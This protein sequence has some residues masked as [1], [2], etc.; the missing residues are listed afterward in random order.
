MLTRL[1][2][3]RT[4]RATLAIQLPALH[5]NQ[6]MIPFFADNLNT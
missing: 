1:E 6:Q 3:R 2:S 4:A 5:P